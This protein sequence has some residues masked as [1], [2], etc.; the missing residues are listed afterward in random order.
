MEVE[1]ETRE[2]KRKVEISKDATG[3]ELLS[4]LGMIPD[5]SLIIVDGKPLPYTEKIRGKKIKIINV[6]TGG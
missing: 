3:E 6:A 4:I 5:S 1:V 2:G